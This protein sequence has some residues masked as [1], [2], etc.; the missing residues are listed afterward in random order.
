MATTHVAGTQLQART[1]ARP[2]TKPFLAMI[3]LVYL[4][5]MHFFMPNPG[6]SGLALA[7]NP[8]TWLLSS[9]AIALGLYQ[10]GTRGQI[11]Y[12]KLTIGL[13]LCCVI[14]TVPVLYPHSELSL[15]VARLSGLWAGFLLFAVLQQFRFSNPQRQ[16]LLWFV[17]IAVFIEALFGWVQYLVL[18]PGNPFGYNTDANRPYGIFQQPNVMASF[19]ATGLALSGYLLTR[20]PIKYQRKVSHVALLYL[21]PAVVLPLLVVLASRTGWLSALLVVVLLIPYLMRFAT[22]KRAVGWLVSVLIGVTIGLGTTLIGE[23]NTLA[24]RKVNLEGPRQ[25]TFP[26]TL[27]MLIEKPFTGY[28][29]GRFE[30]EYLVYTARQH[31]LNASYPPGLAS[32]DH[33][34]NETLYWGVEGGVLPIL[35]MLIA[36]IL[37]LYRIYAAKNGTR[38]AIFSLFI[39]IVL[40]TQLEYPFYHSAIHWVTFI[41][42]IYWVD[43]R[44]RAYRYAQLSIVSQTGLRV[45]SLVLPL[46][47][48]FYMVTTL[49]TNYIL[50]QFELSKPKDPDILNRVSNP[51]VWQERFDWDIYSTYLNI[52]LHQQNPEFIQPYVDWSL[53]VITHKPR[54][55]FYNNLI[56]AYQGLNDSEKAEQIRA[57][58]QFL[59]PR[60][61]FS[62]VQYVP[63]TTDAL[64]RTDEE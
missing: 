33:P 15:S 26:Q 19:L 4:V 8:P 28:G 1:Q 27:D 49:H 13:F 21:I 29:Y 41:L 32:M 64:L 6:G 51:I 60:R 16:R 9:V 22:K 17:V 20:Q 11:R 30:A 55:A 34:H 12:N 5:V 14:M 53:G 59:F 25:Y 36:A 45:A 10:V 47:T 24:E 63:P 35:A 58:A 56:L 44:K 43:Q 48:S 54:P 50:T 7:F 42:L 23:N 61:D 2:L 40:H 57:E 39:P 37:V 52:G 18:E 38:L 62:D 46:V 31:Q 3:G